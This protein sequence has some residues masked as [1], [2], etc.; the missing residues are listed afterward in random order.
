MALRHCKNLEELIDFIAFVIVYSPNRFPRREWP[1]NLE[2]AF[3][4]MRYG[5]DCAAKEIEV[6][7]IIDK[8][9]EILERAYSHFKARENVEATHLLQDLGELL[10][11]L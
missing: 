2:I 3:D 10:E 1:M 5:L 6:M 7:S 8:S 11:S 4:E 9:R